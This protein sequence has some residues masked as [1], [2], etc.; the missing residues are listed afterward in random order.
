[1]DGYFKP[2][3]KDRL[4]ELRL[5]ELEEIEH[6]SEDDELD[7]SLT[8]LLEK[9]HHHL[10]KFHRCPRCKTVT[11]LETHYPYC[12]ECNWDSL[13]YLTMEKNKCAA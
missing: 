5:L 2:K 10:G 1:M 7:F 4:K 13:T 11:Q 9:N 3:L 6:M 12:P 8:D